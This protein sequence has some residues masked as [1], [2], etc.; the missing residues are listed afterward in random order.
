MA[1]DIFQTC[2]LTFSTPI[3]LFSGDR[4]KKGL[5][6]RVVH[7]V[8]RVPVVV[9]EPGAAL[10]VEVGRVRVDLVGR[11]E[12]LDCETCCYKNDG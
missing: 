1:K 9:V 6:T 2:P 10:A 7:Q 12:E 5:D 3:P 8:L 11:F 4:E